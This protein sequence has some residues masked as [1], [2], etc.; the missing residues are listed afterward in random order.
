MTD[1]GIPAPTSF[2]PAS[3]AASRRVG[4]ALLRRI[5]LRPAAFRVVS[6]PFER[7]CPAPLQGGPR[8]SRL[9]PSASS[10][11]RQQAATPPPPPGARRTAE[12]PPCCSR[13]R[14]GVQCRRYA[15]SWGMNTPGRRRPHRVAHR[16]W[17]ATGIV[18]LIAWTL[19]RIRLLGMADLRPPHHGHRRSQRCRR[20][21]FLHEHVSI[22]CWAGTISSSP[23][24]V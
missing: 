3:T 8:V 5:L 19:M 4:P 11:R 2:T 18:L 6:R 21:A 9:R 22:C 15:L 1:E 24:P 16:T 20:C 13:R 17:V 23:A 7:R 14:S 12:P 10:R